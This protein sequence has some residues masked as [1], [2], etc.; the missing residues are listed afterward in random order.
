MYGVILLA[1]QPSVQLSNPGY[2]NH[3]PL[4]PLT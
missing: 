4:L 1:L 2:S 3:T